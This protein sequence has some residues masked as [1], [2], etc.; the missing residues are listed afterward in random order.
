M[1]SAAPYRDHVVHHALMNVLEPLL[2]GRFYPHSY[3]CR[4]GKGTHAGP[5]LQTGLNDPAVCFDDLDHSPALR[6][7]AREGLFHIDVLAGLYGH[8]S[9]GR[10]PVVGYAAS[11]SSLSNSSRKSR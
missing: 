4:R 8:D 5:A 11:M 7:R 10:M 6:H 9:L 2:D 3:A 1:I